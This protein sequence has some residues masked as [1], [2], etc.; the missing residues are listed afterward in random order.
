MYSIVLPYSKS[1]W[2][3]SISNHEVHIEDALCDFESEETETHAMIKM[4][5]RSFCP[6]TH[7]FNKL[8]KIVFDVNRL[9]AEAYEFANLHILRLIDKQ[10]KDRV[11]LRLPN[12]DR[13]FYYRCLLA[14]STNKCR[15][16]TLGNDFKESI[17]A[18]DALRVGDEAKT[19]IDIRSINA[20]VAEQSITMATMATNHLWMN[21]RNRITRFISW[22]HPSLGP[23]FRKLI[24]NAVL[25]TPTKPLGMVFKKQQTGDK[26]KL[27][28][29]VCET[30]RSLLPMKSAKTPASKAHITIPLYEYILSETETA[31]DLLPKHDATK[32]ANK[33][34]QRKQVENIPE[35]VNANQNKPKRFRG[36]TFTLLPTKNGLTISYVAISNMTMMGLFKSIKNETFQG[37]GRDVDSLPFWRKHFNVKMVETV[38]RKFDCRITT[39]GCAV[40][41]Q[42]KKLSAIVFPSPPIN[43]EHPEAT[44]TDLPTLQS[45][46]AKGVDVRSVDPGFTD[47]ATIAS[48]KGTTTHYSSAQYYDT[49][50]YNYSRQKTDRWNKD[51]HIDVKSIQARD[52]SRLYQ[53]E[54]KLKRYLELLPSLLKHRMD[55]N[56]RGMRFKR[57]IGKQ[58]AIKEICD[59]IA[60]SKQTTIVGFGNWNGGKGTPIKRR[61]AG[62]LQEVKFELHK[63]KDVYLEMIHEKNTSQVCS[64]CHQK[65]SNMQYKTKAGVKKI[66]KVLHCKRN[67]T[68]KTS[69]RAHRCGTTWNRDVNASLNILK[70]LLHMIHGSKR[71]D[72]FMVPLQNR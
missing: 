69:E 18:F 44:S 61:C 23:N 68:L 35:K 59:L 7:I 12:I 42:F 24:A 40:S 28:M 26:V 33:R 14:V 38:T 49:A 19:K 37:D 11:V 71:P 27:A 30:M 46:L 1:V 22:K 41:I 70:L 15:V 62:P 45:M 13:N 17:I 67:Q 20:I 3:M 6:D 25:T 52:S 39:D 4:K 57:Y 16:S 5:L 55:R 32:Q 34:K 50:F 9:V 47:V 64:C 10:R 2:C 51:T 66:H 36:R 8:N 65:L 48:I 54:T 29:S 53:I 21:I 58:L 56:Y 63:R 43:L 72:V 60:P 31:Q